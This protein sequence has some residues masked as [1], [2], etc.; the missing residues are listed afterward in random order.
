[1]SNM[2]K[3]SIANKTMHRLRCPI[4]GVYAVTVIVFIVVFFLFAQYSEKK[5]R[6][7]LYQ[8]K[9]QAGKIGLSH[10]VNNAAIPLL[11]EDA[12]SLNALLKEATA[13]NG[14]LYVFVLDD[15]GIVRA[16]TDIRKLGSSFGKFVK[17]DKEVKDGDVLMVTYPLPDG[18]R[19]LDLSRPVTFMKKHLGTVHV[20]LSLPVLQRE[21]EHAMSEPM[22][23]VTLTG[24]VFCVILLCSAL[25]LFFWL[26]RAMYGPGALSA[27]GTDRE[28]S[29]GDSDARVLPLH[30]AGQSM[31][32]G[33][34]DPCGDSS[35]EMKQNHVTVLFAG[36]KGFRAYAE[37]NDNAKLMEDLN[38]YLALATDCIERFGG[39]ID[40]FVGDAVI[41]V[42][43]NSSH[44]AD[45]A[46]RAL[47]AAVTMQ[48]A[49]Q[50]TATDGN[51]LLLKVGIGISSGVVLSGCVGLP[52]RKELTFIGESFKV[53][54]SLNV[55]AGPGEIVM[56]REAYQMIEQRV[57]V[58]PLPPRELIQRTL[59]WENFR[60]LKILDLKD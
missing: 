10:F 48:K 7:L 4:L 36:I 8:E 3:V 31:T 11:D 18:T 26:Q 49:L 37:I 20:G 17:R 54:Y 23:V 27:Q 43:D 32:A 42:F 34:S 39:Y 28:T 13:I 14:A 5:H 6:E 1:M 24:V 19:V 44:Q 38:G 60:L 56:S 21:I 47:R 33:T 25:V 2:Q 41:A 12:L 58:E 53:A 55:M 35:P 45:H 57:S 40:T 50:S 59:S 46:E 16:H 51:P 9:I 52:Q 29:R 22:R 30:G 15:R